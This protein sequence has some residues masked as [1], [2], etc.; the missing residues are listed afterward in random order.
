MVL[1]VLSR[2][3]FIYSLGAG[4]A[5]IGVMPSSAVLPLAV[6][7]ATPAATRGPVLLNRNENPYGPSEKVRAAIQDALPLVNRFPA[8]EYQALVERV[9]ARH[10]VA[11]DH[12]LVGC[13]S[14]DIHRAAALAFLG[15]GKVL[16]TASP[17]FAPTQQY[18]RS[19]GAEVVAVRLNR[20][21]AHDVGAMLA[22]A[23][24]RTGLIYIC[25]PNN[26]TGTI[27]DRKEL[28]VFFAKLP[29]SKHVLMDE[30]YHELAGSAPSY[31]SFI[32]QPVSHPG[33][34]VTRTFSKA[35]GLAGL[36]IGYAVAQPRV[37]DL[38]RPFLGQDN[39]SGLALCAAHAAW[40]DLEGLA[41]SVKRTEDD[42]QEFENRAIARTLRP[43][44][45][46][47]N[48]VTLNTA[49]PAT[50]VIERFRKN[51]VLIGPPLPPLDTY[52]RVTLGR[53]E[54]MNEFWRV[55]DLH[56]YRLHGH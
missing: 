10:K 34:I 17:S 12:V 54:E 52:I 37:L 19:S 24:A 36:R 51:N 47:T 53:P 49:H 6:S 13:G 50:E 30:A 7:G 33:V 8:N 20:D 43:L 41:Q 55:W 56:P 26:P 35:Y 44:S 23:N 32:D 16:V 18:A 22:R 5:S 27:T 48:F 39:V 46:H 25:N 45:S 28:E 38:I 3:Q 14:Q 42:R 4:V 31:I 29:P 11:R 40:D 15:R 2:R 9:A 21:F 1:S